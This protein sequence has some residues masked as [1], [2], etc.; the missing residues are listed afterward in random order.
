MNACLFLGKRSVVELD[1]VAVKEALSYMRGL[2]RL[3][4]VLGV[5][6]DVDPSKKDMASGAVPELGILDF[7]PKRCHRRA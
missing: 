2:I 6:G 7:E 3:A 4:R 5:S 1:A